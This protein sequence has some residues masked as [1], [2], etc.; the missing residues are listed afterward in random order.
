MESHTFTKAGWKGEGGATALVLN[1]WQNRVLPWDRGCHSFSTKLGGAGGGGVSPGLQLPSYPCP[2]SHRKGPCRTSE[3][4]LG[5]EKGALF[6]EGPKK[7]PCL[8]QPP[9][10]L[11]HSLHLCSLS[12]SE[13]SPWKRPR[14]ALPPLAKLTELQEAQA[15]NSR[16]G[17]RA[18]RG[19]ISGPDRGTCVWRRWMFRNCRV[20]CL[21]CTVKAGIRWL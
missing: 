2:L 10:L 8:L 11:A 18:D 14:S 12:E 19:V 9:D 20:I 21:F 16:R 13:G 7:S 5:N 17:Y 1:E 6:R 3:E 15:E 4:L